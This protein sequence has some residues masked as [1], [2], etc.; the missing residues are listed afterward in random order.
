MTC[1]YSPGKTIRRI[2][3]FTDFPG[4]SR[5]CIIE[6][7]NLFRRKKPLSDAPPAAPAFG[8]WLIRQFTAGEPTTRMPFSRLERVCSNAGLLLCAGVYSR[9]EAFRDIAPGSREGDIV[10][11]R[12]ADGFKAS[13]ADRAHTVLAW[14]WDHM[15]TSVAWTA[16]RSGDV[17][18]PRLGTALTGI[19]VAYSL[20]HRE[21]LTAV[22]ELWQRVAAGLIPDARPPDLPAMGHQ[23]LTAF[24]AGTGLP[25]TGWCPGKFEGGKVQVVEPAPP[26]TLG[27]TAGGEGQVPQPVSVCSRTRLPRP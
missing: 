25:A 4:P 5:P 1:G 23:M 6:P 8:E 19:G 14:P 15:A 13:L 10:A 26:W 12:T 17:A 24:E 20:A 3:P 21:Q 22:V 9:P 16:S 7:V 2:L 27:E 11:R 18:E